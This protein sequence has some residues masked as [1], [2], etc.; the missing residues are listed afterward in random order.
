MTQH[1]RRCLV[2]LLTGIAQNIDASTAEFIC[3]RFELIEGIHHVEAILG[4]GS[5]NV[6]AARFG[7]KTGRL[8]KRPM[9]K[10]MQFIPG[11]R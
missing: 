9:L 6:L 2:T 7:R 10:P 11:P 1:D 3:C 4:A 5:A 8:L